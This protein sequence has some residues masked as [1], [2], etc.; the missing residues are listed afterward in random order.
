MIGERSNEAAVKQKAPRLPSNANRAYR[1]ARKALAA[2]PPR[3]RK[4]RCPFDQ[5]V[6]ADDLIERH[7]NL[8]TAGD[9]IDLDPFV[10]R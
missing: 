7:V 2:S 8:D 6:G 4:S 9:R 1:C 3:M 10:E 5:F